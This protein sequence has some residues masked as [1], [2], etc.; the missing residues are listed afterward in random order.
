MALQGDVHVLQTF[1]LSG[2]VFFKSVDDGEDCH[3]LYL[4]VLKA[5][6]PTREMSTSSSPRYRRKGTKL[7]EGLAS[8]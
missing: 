3:V 5:Y 6:F 1:S 8:R 4:D 2:L 7:A